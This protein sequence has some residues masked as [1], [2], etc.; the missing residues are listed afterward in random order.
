MTKK[1]IIKA[2]EGVS[3]HC[4]IGTYHETGI[5]IPAIDFRH[6][7]FSYGEDGL[8]FDDRADIPDDLTGAVYRE[9]VILEFMPVGA[10]ETEMAIKDGS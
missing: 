7:V 3:D 1:E 5:V 6:G 4:Q 9:A 2:L 10:V 8:V